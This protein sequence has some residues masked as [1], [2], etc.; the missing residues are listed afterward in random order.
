M[1][2]FKLQEKMSDLAFARGR[3]VTIEEVA[4]ATGIHRSTLSKMNRPTGANVNTDNLDRLCYF[5]GCDLNEL[6]EYIRTEAL[7]P[8]KKTGEGK[9][10]STD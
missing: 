9:S 6:V 8:K 3:R 10:G 1:I 5:L 4:E 7:P 2:R